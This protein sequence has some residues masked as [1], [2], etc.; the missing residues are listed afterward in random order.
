MHSF[1]QRLSR[2]NKIVN[3]TIS[4]M[5][6]IRESLEKVEF[7]KKFQLIKSRDLK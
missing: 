2:E 6:D 5:L 4:K 3:S 7:I 1:L